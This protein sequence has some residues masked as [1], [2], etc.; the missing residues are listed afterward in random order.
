VEELE[1]NALELLKQREFEKAARLYLQLAVAHPE[2]EN[3]LITAANCY[4]SLGDKKLAKGLYKKALSVN[5]AALTALLNLASL[6]Y[7]QKKYDKAETC[8]KEALA[9]DNDNFSALLNLGNIAYAKGDFKNALQFYTR[10]YEKNP[11][12]YNA[13]INI[14]NTSYNLSHYIRAIEFA[15]MA[16]EKRPNSVDPYIIAGNAY[17]ELSKNEEATALLKQASS[18]APAS[19]W[20]ANSIANLFRKMGDYRLCLHYAWKVF[21]LKGKNITV[22]DHINFAYMLY[23]AK[24]EH[25]DE[26]VD[27][28]LS[29]WQQTFPN[30]PIVCHSVAA[31]TGS[32]AVN[33]ADLTYVKGLFD[34]F[35]PTFD[36]ILQ[37]LDYRVPE[38]IAQSLKQNLK[39]KLFK[40]RRILDLGCGT[41]LCAEAAR[42]FFPNE[43]F[44]G[45]DI[46]EKMLEQAGI[47]NI[48]KELYNDDII[49]FLA[50]TA[51]PFHAVIA[52]DVLT[53]AG[54]LKQ[55]FRLLIRA[56]KFNGLFIFSVSKNTYNQNNYFLTPSGRFVHTLAYIN[57]LLKHCGFEAISINETTLRHEGE[58]EIPGY[59]ITAQ[60][61][62]EVVF[63]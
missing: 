44:Y 21:A 26:L 28:Y 22:D 34:G 51:D 16:M 62:L 52:G 56:V 18:I 1:Q 42:R 57:R 24:D 12:S 50:E 23:E 45:V 36:E 31:L 39:T 29:R 15:Q 60:K 33:T 30:N 27:K 40:K 7:E 14:A 61:R 46:S 43:E 41:G 2:N 32:G 53:Y 13:I 8:A 63:E 38:L 25:N 20:L 3:F 48:Y 54:D 47:K 55:L 49:S 6:Y 10:L 19:D 4:D 35:A 11:N 9:L 37:A 58:K 17:I 59:V 5:P